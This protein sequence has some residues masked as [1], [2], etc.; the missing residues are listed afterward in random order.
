N[1]C[2]G[3]TDEDFGV[4]GEVM[5]E[6]ALFGGDEGK[7]KGEH[8]GAGACLDGLVVCADDQVSLVCSSDVDARPDNTCNDVDDDCNG[9][10]DDPFVS[11]ADV[12]F[13]PLA[14][15]RSPSDDGKGKGAPCGVG[16]CVAAGAGVVACAA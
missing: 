2:D 5:L 7:V 16:A 1:D 3:L 12:I 10:T 15:A 4:D 11:G 13:E 14:G 9:V 6:G 8:C